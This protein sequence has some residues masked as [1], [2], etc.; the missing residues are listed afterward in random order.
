MTLDNEAQRELLLAIFK[1]I[2][3]PG[4]VLEQTYALKKAI[5]SASIVKD[6]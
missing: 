4:Q 5:E 1:G 6:P 3:I 2:N